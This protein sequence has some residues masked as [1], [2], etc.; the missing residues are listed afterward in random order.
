MQ[1]NNTVQPVKQVS[2]YLQ[3]APVMEAIR[4]NNDR[5]PSNSL[6][7]DTQGTIQQNAQA[8]PPVTLYNAHGILS[9][10]APNTLLGYA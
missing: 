10:T 5:R 7:I 1:T 6:P 2:E 9:K 3:L 8:V 4:T